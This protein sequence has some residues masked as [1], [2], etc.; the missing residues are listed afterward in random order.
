MFFLKQSFLMCSLGL[1]PVPYYIL[2]PH[3]MCCVH[4]HNMLFL[5]FTIHEVKIFKQ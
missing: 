3:S 4:I 1:S 2:I 5:K